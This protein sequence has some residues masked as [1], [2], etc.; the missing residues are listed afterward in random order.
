MLPTTAIWRQ[1]PEKVLACRLEWSQRNPDV[2]LA[3]LRAVY[4]A[5]A[6]CER[7]EHQPQ[8]AQCLAEPRYVGAPAEILLRGLRNRLAFVAD[9]AP[10][11]VPDFYAVARNAATFPWTNHA[12]WFYSQMVR[13]GQVS[14]AARDVAQVRATY[15]PDLYR[16]AL[17]SLDV[18]IPAE[19]S[20]IEPSATFFD[21]RSFDPADLATYVAGFG[22]S[23]MNS[24]H[25]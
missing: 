2:L 25:R 5:A 23:R 16:V 7:H 22:N 3:L 9:E 19:D 8:L 15:R 12:L 11:D 4:R 13:W 14:F 17:A 21:A 20:R 10:R 18:A 1:S 24:V 6:W